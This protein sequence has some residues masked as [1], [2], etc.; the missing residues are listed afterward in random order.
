[1]KIT[2]TIITSSTAAALLYGFVHLVWNS[3]WL[4][5]LVARDIFKTTFPIIY[6]QSDEVDAP[7]LS[8]AAPKGYLLHLF[9]K[10][11]KPATLIILLLLWDWI[12]PDYGVKRY[13]QETDSI[14]DT[15]LLP[16]ETNLE[17]SGKA[18][19]NEIVIAWEQQQSQQQGNIWERTKEM[20]WWERDGIPASTS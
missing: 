18:Q 19:S 1:M 6:P 13:H 16:K 12:K 5:K 14:E 4:N 7:A 10:I 15:T 3:W 9:H 11:C 8:P 17:M 2:N 20:L